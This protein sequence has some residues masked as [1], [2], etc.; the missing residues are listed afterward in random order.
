MPVAEPSPIASLSDPGGLPIGIRI[1][2]A[3]WIAVRT[4]AGVTLWH[5]PSGVHH[6]VVSSTSR[7]PAIGAWET[8]PTGDRM[9]LSWRRGAMR[10]MDV[11]G[12]TIRRLSL[13]AAAARYFGGERPGLGSHLVELPMKPRRVGRAPEVDPTRP[14]IDHSRPSPPYGETCDAA[15]APDGRS[16][17]VAY[18]QAY[19]LVWRIA[20]ASLLH[21]LGEAQSHD[22]GARIYR[23][24]WSPDGAWLLTADDQGRVRLWDVASGV[25]R[26]AWRVHTS[27]ADDQDHD[28]SSQGSLG[29]I[30][31]IAFAPGAPVV[32][33][34]DGTRIRRWRVGDGAE[35]APL[36]G[37]ED[38]HPVLALRTGMPG[39]HDIRCSADGRRILTVGN[40]ATL[41]VW[42]TE[43]GREIWQVCPDPCCMDWGD[44]SADG[45]LVAWAACPGVRVYE[46]GP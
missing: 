46:V 34:A 28:W 32:L 33:A 38:G 37:H 29:G 8:S 23:V 17:V 12:H 4:S 40:D 7:S 30:G 3:E 31:A 41:R 21:S 2:S 39:I 20:S 10:V 16:V 1:L 14:V 9:L 42:D 27:R 6:D 45:R 19:A 15:F 43:S 13:P 35:L 5:L 18:G 11:G 36:V 25:E 26:R 44:I 24:A 22:G